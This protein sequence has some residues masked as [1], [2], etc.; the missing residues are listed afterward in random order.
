M[1][2]KRQQIIE[3]SLELFREH[4]MKA[5]SM[6]KLADACSMSK[7][8]LYLHFNSKKELLVAGIEYLQDRL[9][10]RIDEIRERTDL[11]PR[12]KLREQ[13]LYQFND[14]SENQAYTE[15]FYKE[16]GISLDESMLL[17]AEKTRLT[18][19]RIQ[20]EFIR[21]AFDDRTVPYLIDLS[22]IT[23]GIVNEYCA[24]FFLEE[25]EVDRE[26]AADFL[27]FLLDKIVD[28]LV[29]EK[30]KP[31]LT[32]TLFEHRQVV[33][34]RVAE[35]AEARLRGALADM[36]D[37]VEGLE[38]AGLEKEDATAS[39]SLLA[40]ELEKETPNRVLVQGLLANLRDY[41]EL[42]EPRRV[43]ATELKIKLL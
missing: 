14:F 18:W 41:R 15:M 21:L 17:L 16:A 33:D 34:Q 22:V 2:P 3:T 32:A 6:Q 13:L 25:A 39:L 24:L 31:F 4:G 43:I 42:Q 29:A 20:E 35:A 8:A 19:Q 36:R 37:V 1:D 23:S 30:P 27:I 26:R 9:I 38:L 5:V 28:G 12:Q 7:G 10:E 40:E 11:T